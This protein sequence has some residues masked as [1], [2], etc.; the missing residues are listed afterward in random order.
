MVHAAVAEALPGEV[1]VADDAGAGAGRARRRPPRDAGEGPRASRRSWWTP[2][3]ATWT[4]CA[5]SASRSGRATCA[6]G[7][8]EARPGRD[9]GAGRGRRA[10]RSVRATSSSSTPTARSS[11]S[12]SASRRCSRPRASARSASARSARSSRRASSR[13][14]STACDASSK[15]MTR[16]VHDLA[17]IGHA[18]LL[19]PKPEESLRFFVDVLGMEEE[20]R[21]G[22]SVFLR[23]WGDYLRYSLKLTESP[24]AGL[25]HVALRAWSPEALDRRVAAVEASG[26]RARLD[27]RGRRSRPGVPLH[28]PRR[29]RLRALLRGRALRG[30]RAPAAVVAEPAA[31]LRRPRRGG[32][33]ARPRQRARGRRSRE[34]HVRAGRARLPAVRADRARR[35]DRDGRLAQPL[36]RRARAHLRR[37]RVRRDRPATPPRVLGRHARGVPARRRRLRR[38]TASPSRRRR[39]STGSRRASSCTASSPEGTGSRSRPVDT[40]CTTRTSSRSRGP[41]RSARAASTGA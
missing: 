4:S 3:C 1:L 32:Q 20:A 2:R 27:R 5:S 38:R 37:G 16:A 28:G 33:A 41:R 31:A 24:Q 34:P 11:S 18:E 10:R 40:S 25:G 35:R 7:G 6:C 22:Q 23:G 8:G 14:T 13:T 12:A 9:R 17:R 29:P 36:D 26:T 19:T 15:S 21:D 30:A 39:R